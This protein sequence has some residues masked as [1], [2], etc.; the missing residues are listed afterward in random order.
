M[1]STRR[2]V[3]E[4]QDVAGQMHGSGRARRIGGLAEEH[5]HGARFA[6]DFGL[7]VLAQLGLVRLHHRDTEMP[8]VLHRF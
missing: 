3:D 8:R 2:L 5:V 6:E 1:S 4:G 7:E